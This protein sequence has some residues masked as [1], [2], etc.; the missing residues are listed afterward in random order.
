MNNPFVF[1]QS[2]L[3]TGRKITWPT[4]PEVVYSS[5][6]VFVIAIIAGVIFF[7]VDAVLSEVV[8]SILGMSF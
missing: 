1:F 5:M 2:V 3:E 8:L 6:L 7:L 4:R